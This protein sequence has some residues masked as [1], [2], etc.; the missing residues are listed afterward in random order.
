[1]KY[2]VWACLLLGTFGGYGQVKTRKSDIVLVVHGGA[3]T[4][5]KS[6]M[7][8]EL[9]KEYTDGLSEALKKGYDILERGG[10]SLDAVEAAI[11]V[12]ENNPLF[13]AGKG[14]VF[15]NE[16]KNELDASIMDGKTLS[17]G[18]VAGVTTV[19]NPITAARA[20]MEK[21]N[22]VIMAGAGADKFAAQAGLEIVDPSY[23][24]TGQRWKALQQVKKEDSLK[25]ELDHSGKKSSSYYFTNKD[26]KFGTVG[27]VALD[28]Y[29]NLAA[30]TSTGGMTNK[31]FGRVGDSPIIGAGTYAD[32]NTCAISCT[33][34]GEYYIRL[35]MAKTI[36]DMM[37]FGKIPLKNAA[38]EMVMKRLPALGG[39]GGLI[40]VDSK[41][42][43]AMPFNTEGMY[44]GFMKDGKAEV[45]IYKE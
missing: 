22:H 18:A 20:V 38:D 6:Q 19:K 32:N 16:G 1:M 36:S 14:A 4:I 39:D 5:L 34:W 40:A 29:G 24:F 35:V 41:G 13:N 8:Q 10:S 7:T 25:T 33:G 42:N 26:S 12:L 37:E 30:A 17:A 28:Q 43:I 21:S 2:I 27:A 31:R 23:F 3:G 9:E 44:R 15:T 45:K 11:K